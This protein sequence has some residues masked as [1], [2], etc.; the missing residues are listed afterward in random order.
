MHQYRN[1]A[2]LIDNEIKFPLGAV[3]STN[4]KFFAH[5]N[6][7]KDWGLKQVYGNLGSAITKVSAVASDLRV[8]KVPVE[9]FT[10]KKQSSQR[11]KTMNS[12]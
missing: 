11:S 9:F 12:K 7:F 5:L 4:R 10:I 1:E 6:H 3:T 2:R 8:I